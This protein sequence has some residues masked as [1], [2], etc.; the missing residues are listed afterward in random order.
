VSRLIDAEPTRR[1][2]RELAAAGYP[3]TWIAARAY[4]SPTG[5]GRIRSGNST[6]ITPTLAH[7]IDHL[8]QQLADTPPDQMGVPSRAI[9]I[10][11]ITAA[12]N[13]WTRRRQRAAT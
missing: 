6:R 9:S 5:L 1:Q 7:T 4:A 2:L 3:L 8:H 12:R 13:H 11:R 10:S